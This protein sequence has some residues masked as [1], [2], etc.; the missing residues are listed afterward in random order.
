MD[1]LDI[2]FR[3]LDTWRH[4]PAYQ[5]ER[6]ADIFFS[7]YLK[8]VVEERAGIA[9]EDE[10]IPE[11][12][13][14]RSLASS[15][16]DDGT[17]TKVDYALF[18]KDRSKVFFVELKTDIRSRRVA[19][20]D[21]YL[22]VVKRNGFRQIVEGIRSLILATKEHRKYNHLSTALARLGYLTL[23]ADLGEHLFS[24]PPRR[25]RRTKLKQIAVCPIDAPVEVL[26]VQPDKDGDR[27]IDFDTFA[28]HVGRFD[29]P[30]SR[31]FAEHLL[32]WR[33]A[34]GTCVPEG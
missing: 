27:C 6:R 25:G 1:P 30:L 23:P 2:V 24:S 12:P 3:N 5:L 11:L 15:E 10:I 16:R 14:K 31:R 22:E 18:A 8:A 33:V 34:A 9:L 20:D 4:L 21:N 32:R 29:D 26:Y 7:V 17:S 19:Q 28:A 13:I